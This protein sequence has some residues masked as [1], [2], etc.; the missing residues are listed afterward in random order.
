MNVSIPTE[1]ILLL[2]VLVIAWW[3]GVWGL[4]EIGVEAYARGSVVRRCIA[5][6]TLV[7]V[8]IAYILWNPQHLE[9]FI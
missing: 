5:Y 2:S 9:K 1:N 6:G 3:I 8:V 7:L 4:C